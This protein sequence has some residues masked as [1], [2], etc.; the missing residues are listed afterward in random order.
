MDYIVLFIKLKQYKHIGY[1]RPTN[2]EMVIQ[3][4]AMSKLFNQSIEF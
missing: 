2:V 3:G 4:S 1:N